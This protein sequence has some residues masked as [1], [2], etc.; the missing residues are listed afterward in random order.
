MRYVYVLES[1]KNPGRHYIGITTDLRQRLADHNA[2]K[3]PYTKRFMPWRLVVY[4]AFTDTDAAHAFERYLKAGSGHTFL[5]RHF[6]PAT[7]R[8]PI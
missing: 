6:L 8:H 1:L 2:G 5:K 4:I 7:C 3:S